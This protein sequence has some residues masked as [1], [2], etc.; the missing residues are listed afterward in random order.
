MSTD[1]HP[2]TLRRSDLALL[3]GV[4][5]RTIDRGAMTGRI[6]PGARVGRSVIWRRA[7][8]DRWLAAGCPATQRR[9][10]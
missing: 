1:K 6:P 8:I 9:R 4:S 2:D 10:T 3:L 5:V 7:D